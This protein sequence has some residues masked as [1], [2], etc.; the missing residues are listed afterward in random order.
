M[1]TTSPKTLR[2]RGYPQNLWMDLFDND[3][4]PENLEEIIES[5]LQTLNERDRTFVQAHYQE[6][7]TR[8]E[9][10]ELA[11]IKESC[12][13][14][15]IQ[16]IRR[17]LRREYYF[18]EWKDH[19]DE[20]RERERLLKSGQAEKCAACGLFLE[21][22]TKAYTAN[23]DIFCSE[24]CAKNKKKSVLLMARSEIRDTEGKIEKVKKTI[25]EWEAV[26]ATEVILGEHAQEPIKS[27]E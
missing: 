19:P 17:N 3:V 20:M 13:E 14:D 5:L 15:K 23:D 2:Q 21:P 26:Q 25:A 8:K 7:R 18:R 1:K 10:T 11:G 27:C 22:G 12:L 4:Y 16:R 9:T 24:A 6:F